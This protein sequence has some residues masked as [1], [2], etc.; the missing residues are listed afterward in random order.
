[1]RDFYFTP[2]GT[3]IGRFDDATQRP[4]Y[5][6]PLATFTN[7][8][9]LEA[10]NGNVYRYDP[11]AGEQVLREAGGQGA[12]VFLPN[13]REISNVVMEDEFSAMIV[14]QNAPCPNH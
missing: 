9:A 6:L 5:K 14:T 7:A 10:I 1:M 8:N 2:D 4:L 3:M 13:S 12:G 11:N